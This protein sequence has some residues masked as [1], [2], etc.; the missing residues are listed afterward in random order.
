MA[1]H[2][3]ILAW[4]ITWKRSLAVYSPWVHRRVR[5]DLVTKQQLPEAHLVQFHKD[6]L[7]TDVCL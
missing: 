2:S 4:E 5:H 7:K 1:N 3:T 6:N